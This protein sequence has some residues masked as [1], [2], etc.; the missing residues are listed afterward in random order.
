MRGDAIQADGLDRD[1]T[2]QQLVLGLVDRAEGSGAQLADHIIATGNLGRL[3]SGGGF[4]HGIL[5]PIG[6]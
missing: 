6:A 1:Q 5:V 2:A 3:G 4:V